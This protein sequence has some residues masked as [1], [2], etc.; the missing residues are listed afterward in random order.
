[1]IV[2]PDVNFPSGGV[3]RLYR[4][5][6]YLKDAGYSVF[7][8]HGENNEDRYVPANAEIPV[9]YANQVK[10]F[11]STD[12]LMV[13]EVF[14]GTLEHLSKLPCK[15]IVV[16]LSWIYIHSSLPEGKTWKSFGITDVIANCQTIADFISLTM[17]LPATVIRSTINP[18]IFYC[19]PAQKKNQICFISRK[20]VDTAKIAKILMT[21]PEKFGVKD[22]VIV[23]MKD[24][25]QEEYAKVLRES[26]IY[27][28]TTSQEG[29]PG[30]LLEAF[31]SGCCVVGY[32]GPA[33]REFC[34]QGVP[35]RTLNVFLSG[36]GDFISVIKWFTEKHEFYDLKTQSEYIHR[37]YAQTNER[38]DLINFFKKLSD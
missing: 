28:S 8:L 15:K 31:A 29:A 30:P 10:T 1:L 7:M 27:L 21:N 2:T 36:A 17:D 3:N 33:D 32:G 38:D 13:P 24:L 25:K 12:V 11:E 23:P 35:P 6:G 18:T 26:K 19:D 20:D 16:A 9:L 5:G 34:L 4:Y 22:W 37:K 14:G